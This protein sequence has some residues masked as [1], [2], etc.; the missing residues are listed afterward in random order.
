MTEQLT[1]LSLKVQIVL[2]EGGRRI[3]QAMRKE[4]GVTAIEYAVIAVAV[5]AMLLTVFGSKDGS[6]VKAITDKFNELAKNINGT[7]Q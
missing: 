3:C 5:S 2:S 4:N 7:I 6:F 1:S